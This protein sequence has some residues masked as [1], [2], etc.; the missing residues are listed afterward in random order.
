MEISNKNKVLLSI[1]LLLVI[2]LIILTVIK[3]R[4]QLQVIKFVDGSNNNILQGSV[5]IDNKY[6]SDINGY[7][8]NLSDDFCKSPHEI[9]IVKKDT[10]VSWLTY[11][12]DCESKELILITD[13][14]KKTEKRLNNIILKFMVKETKEPLSG[15]LFFNNEFIANIT[16][17]YSI[18]REL[19]GQITMINLTGAN[20]NIE[21]NHQSLWCKTA[22]L[23]DYSNIEYLVPKAQIE[24]LLNQS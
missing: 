9:S 21:W 4:N 8:R 6:I 13:L 17:N 7:L 23:L 20:Y 18:P 2:I 15:S 16:G 22:G 3:S 5:Y 14:S 10:I 11:P 12:S 24:A 19:C 1:I